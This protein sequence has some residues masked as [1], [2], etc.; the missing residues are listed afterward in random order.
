MDSDSL[1][2]LQNQFYLGNYKYLCDNPLPSKSDPSYLATVCY[3]ARS[4]IALK[5]YSAA[6]SL[7]G[8]DT[9]PPS[10]ALTSLAKYLS[11][12]GDDKDTYLEE[13]RDLSIEIEDGFEGDSEEGA[14]AGVVKV[15]A[16][17][18][19]FTEGEV[20]EALTTLGAGCK[21]QDIE[22]VALI[23]HIYLSIARPD[24]AKKEYEAAK[25]WADDSLLIQMVEAS[26]GLTVGSRTLQTA[27]Y[28]YAEQVQAP[29]SSTNPAIITAKGISHLLLG[30]YSEAESAFNEALSI[31]PNYAEA[32]AAK[33]TLAELKGKKGEADEAISRL[34]S[35]HPDHILLKDFAEK[36][37]AFDTAASQFALSAEA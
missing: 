32:L 11:A 30:A 23:V 8:S 17:T 12:K 33:V 9:S 16:A 21:S 20:E 5:N 10:R 26:I 25:K 36:E 34:H 27:Q 4:Q 6:L 35:S 22:C 31:E 13:L 29:G 14:G 3:T 2:Y 15:V 37:D 7:L 24:L 19:F 18:A 1:F 28:I